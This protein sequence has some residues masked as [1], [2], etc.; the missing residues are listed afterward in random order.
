MPAFALQ[1]VEGTNPDLFM[2]N[3]HEPDSSGDPDLDDDETYLV[4]TDELW[5]LFML[6][7][8]HFNATESI[9]VKGTVLPEDERFTVG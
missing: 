8:Q 3:I 5:G 7:A 1:P 4:R 2:L 6:L 9:R